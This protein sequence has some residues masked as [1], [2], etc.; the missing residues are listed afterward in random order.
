MK[1]FSP[2]VTSLL[3][4]PV[5]AGCSDSGPVVGPPTEIKDVQTQE[6]KDAMEK[7]GKK[8]QTKGKPKAAPAAATTTP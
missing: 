2:I 8:M 4:W 1:R 3:L 7:A 6:F 5:I